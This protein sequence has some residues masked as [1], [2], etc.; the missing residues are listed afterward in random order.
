MR[1]CRLRAAG[2][3]V[4]PILAVVAA[5][6]LTTAP[7]A[8]AALLP[9]PAP[10][11]LGPWHPTGSYLRDS[12]TSNQGLATVTTSVGPTTVYR[13]SG[14]IPLP[15]LLQGW[16]HIGDPGARGGYVVDAYQ[17]PAGASSKLYEVTA[18]TGQQYD[19]VHPLAPLSPPELYNNSFAAVS[20]DGRWL[21]SGEWLAM[22]RLLVFRLPAPGTPQPVSQP[23]PL[24]GVI[25][26]DRTVRNVQG[27]DFVT[28][29]QLLC[30]SDDP[31]TDLFGVAKPLLQVDLAQPLGPDAAGAVTALGPLPQHSLCTG[32][33]ETEG[34]DVAPDGELRVEVVPPAPCV[35]TTRVYAYRRS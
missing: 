25:T 6:V 35:I 31:G 18:P 4:L 19:F 34:I 30:S 24:A 20:P 22:R 10:G 32:T 9:G 29:R 2:S 16:Q 5:L 28:D 13:G 17:G 7:P 27:C 14:T 26:L 15:L 3:T 8:H 21:V 33:F 23:L 11:S 12:L 1:S